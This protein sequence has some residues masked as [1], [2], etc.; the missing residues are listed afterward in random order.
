MN[1]VNLADIP[2]VAHLSN[3]E[4]AVYGIHD[5]LRADGKEAAKSPTSSVA[6]HPPVSL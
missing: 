4:Q 5:I 1:M 3:E 2:N 6:M